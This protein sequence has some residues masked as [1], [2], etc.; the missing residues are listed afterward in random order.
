M[1]YRKFLPQDA[2]IVVPAPR[3]KPSISVVGLGYVGAVS[4]ACLASL[5]HRVIG[6]DLSE[7]KV[8]MIGRGESPIH[9]DQL[10]E[11]LKQGV[12]DGLISTSDDL[13]QAVIDTDVT[14][15]SVG[16]PT[17]ADGGCDY[18]FIKL[19]SDAMA[20]GLRDKDGFHVFAMRCSIPPGTTMKVMAPILE[21]IS[22]K[23]VGRDFGICFNPEFLREGVAIDDFHNPPKT[24]IGT[25]D[26]ATAEIMRRIYASVDDNPILTTIEVAE[27]IKYVDNVW[28]ATKVC[29]ANEVGRLCKPLGVDSHAVMDIFTQDQK[30]NLSSYYL[31]PG[32]AYGGSCLPKE[33]R[34][35]QHIAEEMGVS[36]PL[37][38]NLDNSN[39]EQIR[40]ATEMLRGTGA[41]RVGV[42]GIAFKP[43]TDDL[44]ESPIL[45]VMAALHAEGIELLVHDEAV[46][47]DTPVSDL[48]PYVTHGS[49][50]LSQLAGALKDML[51]DTVEDVTSNVDAV[52]VCHSNDTYRAAVSANPD[53]PVIDVVRLFASSPKRGNLQGIGW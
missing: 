6:V 48:L 21:A 5:G 8:K 39:K 34:A 52:I 38:G 33:V 37:I 2:E 47:A 7:T 35:V 26:F 10:S 51:R 13:S 41:R 30:L 4:T 14:F 32:F 49:K 15:V 9:E 42:F 25:T 22:G 31:K 36:L 45:E 53:L 16:T 11:T 18:T 3:H 27:T 50:G 23:V 19:A 17:A 28:H 40:Q 43:G 44:R 29:F 1:E 20:R 46:S 24:V 12:D